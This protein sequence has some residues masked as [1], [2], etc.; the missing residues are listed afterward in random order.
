[1]PIIAKLEITL[2]DK[3]S[4]NVQGPIDNKLLAYGLLEAA[5]DAIQDHNAARAA[6]AAGR[7]PLALSEEDR[8][9][10]GAQALKL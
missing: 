3:G 10:I 4:I 2:D 5:H 6:Q 1:M 9:A 8:A 7:S